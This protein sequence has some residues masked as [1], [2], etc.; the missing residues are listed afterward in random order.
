MSGI[1]ISS[2]CG[3]I[4]VS[5]PI[6][7]ISKNPILQNQAGVLVSGAT[8]TA[9]IFTSFV[10]QVSLSVPGGSIAVP[11]PITMISNNPILQNQAGVLVSGAT[12]QGTVA[13]QSQVSRFHSDLFLSVNIKAC[14]K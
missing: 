7:K 5:V 12:V 6:T 13:Q 3:S 1:P 2:R 9:K 14:M 11:V 10:C 8:V 4:A